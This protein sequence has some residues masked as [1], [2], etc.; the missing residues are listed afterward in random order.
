[1]TD[2]AE[3]LTPKQLRALNKTFAVAGVRICRVHQG[4]PL[5]LDDAHFYRSGSH[6]WLEQTCKVC[7]KQIA[8]QRHHERMTTDAEYVEHRRALQRDEYQRT[9]DRKRE[10]ARNNMRRRKARRFRKMLAAEIG[11][12]S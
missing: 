3:R 12:A 6:R 5:P 1:M 10:V 11:G 7:R 8:L 4:H 9:A 2:D